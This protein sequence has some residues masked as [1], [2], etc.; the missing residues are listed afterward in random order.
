MTYFEIRN[1][2]TELEE[3][4]DLYAEYVNFTNRSPDNVPA[5]IVRTKMEPLAPMVVDT[6][7]K[8]GLG[9]VVVKDAPAR[10]GRKL[11]INVIKAIFRERLMERYEISDSA[12]LH[13]LDQG[14]AKYRQKLWGQQLQ[15]FN[16]FFWLFHFVL[17]ISKIPILA[18]KSA[19]Y[20]TR[21][22]ESLTSVRLLVIALQLICYF[23]LIKWTGVLTFIRFDILSR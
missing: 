4:R 9:G 14:I 20:D 8:V 2:L 22:A 12:A 21:H 17:F 7:A 16:P 5:R 15:L 11:K 19:G 1:R 13:V 23:I 6:L 18:F 3:F 10:G